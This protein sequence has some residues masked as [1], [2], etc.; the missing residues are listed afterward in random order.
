MDTCLVLTAIDVASCESGLLKAREYLE[1]FSFAESR[2]DDRDFQRDYE[3][4]T[5]AARENW[6]AFT[7]EGF[8][9]VAA[10]ATSPHAWLR[11]TGELEI[12]DR[13]HAIEFFAYPIAQGRAGISVTF[14]GSIYD[15]IYSHRSPLDEVIDEE[16]RQDFM[17]LLHLLASAFSPEG[18]ALKKLL[19]DEDLGLHLHTADLR[20]Y[21]VAPTPASIR[22]WQFKLVAV[23][24]PTVQRQ[25]VE[26]VWGPENVRATN[27]GYL[28]YESIAARR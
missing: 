15:A 9:A 14:G 26:T 4:T 20:D 8:S 3:K 6:E 12:A 19:G 28:F 21:L 11:L 5:A 7:S 17:A 2:Y 22:K 24:N 25:R 16:A 1:R 18:Y 23:R 27:S 13:A 10:S